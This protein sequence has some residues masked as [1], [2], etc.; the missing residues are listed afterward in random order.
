LRKM[1]CKVLPSQS[2]FIFVKPNRPASEIFTELRKD[3]FIVRYFNLPRISEFI[4][5]TMGTRED[6][7]S[8]LEEMRQLDK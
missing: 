2:N 7:E 5:V 3:G 6:M 1:G 8:F 4:R